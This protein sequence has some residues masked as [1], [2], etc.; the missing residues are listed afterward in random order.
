MAVE[1]MARGGYIAAERRNERA[2]GAAL[3]RGAWRRR[4]A[5]R[6]MRLRAA[7]VGEEGRDIT[8][9]TVEQLFDAAAIA[10]RVEAI[11]GE[12]HSR[13]PA[14]FTLVGILTGSFVFTAD[15]VRAL[16]RAGVCP[17][18]EFMRL[19][20]YG[21]GR[22]S[23][24]EVQVL[25]SL[26]GRFQ[27]EPVVIVDDIQDTGRTLQVARRIL[28]DQGAAPILTCALLDKPERREVDFQADITGF[29]IPDVFV[30]GY[31][32]DWAERYRHLPWIG[33]VRDAG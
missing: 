9:A 27:G 29:T 14:S 21:M 12:I 1:P 28:E 23:A 3:A 26:S 19:A 32:I 25:S 17:K 24:G 7:S 2:S 8:A 16:D 18:V 11:A 31:G 15:L 13:M 4:A 10:A 30:V 33:R 6:T 5:W 22:T 20:S